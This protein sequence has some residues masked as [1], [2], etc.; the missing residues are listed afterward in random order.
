MKKS[1]RESDEGGG[2]RPPS[3]KKGRRRRRP[4]VALAG[5]LSS[6]PPGLPPGSALSIDRASI[7]P[8][9]RPVAPPPTPNRASA[10]HG[11][12]NTATTTQ[13]QQGGGALGRP[14]S[15]PPRPRNPKSI[16][17]RGLAVGG[18]RAAV[19]PTRASRGKLMVSGKEAKAAEEE[20]A[21]GV[22]RREPARGG[23]RPP[24]RAARP[25]SN[26]ASDPEPPVGRPCVQY[27][28]RRGHFDRH[29]ADRDAT[30][31]AALDFPPPPPLPSL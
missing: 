11:P 7:Q 13:E 2:A 29:V 26:A 6:K 10:S 27:R 1:K 30:S 14:P 18:R 25:R 8:P 28:H 17:Q 24:A 21:G 16:M 3:E 4:A 5:S 22:P 23:G 19:A 31:H 20:R 15:R 9:Y 12:S